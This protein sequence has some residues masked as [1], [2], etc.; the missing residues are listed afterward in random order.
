MGSVVKFSKDGSL[1]SLV[2]LLTQ[3]RLLS[4]KLQFSRSKIFGRNQKIVTIHLWRINT[5]KSYMNECS[6]QE[7]LNI[8]GIIRYAL[9]STVPFPSIRLPRTL[10]LANFWKCFW[11]QTL[12]WNLLPICHKFLPNQVTFLVLSHITWYHMGVWRNFIGWAEQTLYLL[13][14]LLNA[15]YSHLCWHLRL[16]NPC[17]TLFTLEILSKYM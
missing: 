6:Y 15:I 9:C 12:R 11:S 16:C 5:A 4:S 7:G 1:P 10:N 14:I 3:M 2:K 8:G 13:V 17:L